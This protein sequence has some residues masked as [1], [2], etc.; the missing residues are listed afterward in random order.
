MRTT[1]A[2]TVRVERVGDKTP[3]ADLAA[4][5]LDQRLIAHRP[6]RITFVR[7]VLH[8]EAGPARPD[9]VR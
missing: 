4:G 5:N 1:E 7:E 2:R 8:A 3:P 6:K 9:H